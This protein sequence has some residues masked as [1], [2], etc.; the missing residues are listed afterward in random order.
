MGHSAVDAVGGT[1]RGASTTSVARREDTDT[2]HLQADYELIFDVDLLFTFDQDFDELPEGGELMEEIDN[3]VE[4]TSDHFLRLVG[5]D[6][7]MS[8]WDVDVTYDG[9]EGGLTVGEDSQ[10]RMTLEFQVLLTAGFIIA[11]SS[12]SMVTAREALDDFDRPTYIA[13]FVSLASPGN[14]APR[15]ETFRSVG[16]IGLLSLFC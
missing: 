7:P 8:Y 13:D 15:Y 10:G 6:F 4:Q 16:M 5:A 11:P 1:L 2:R 3:I 14:F 9:G 12:P